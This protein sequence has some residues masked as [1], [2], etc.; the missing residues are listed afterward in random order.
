M[1]RIFLHEFLEKI[2]DVP[3]NIFLGQRVDVRPL[4]RG[5]CTGLGREMH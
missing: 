2:E 5:F 4:L 3:L 1:A